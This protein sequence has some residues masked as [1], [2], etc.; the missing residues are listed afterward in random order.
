MTD[1]VTDREQLQALRDWWGRQGQYIVM[2]IAVALIALLGYRLWQRYQT[3]KKLEASAAYQ[4]VMSLF[5]QP[6]ITRNNKDLLQRIS[7]LKQKHSSSPYASLAALMAAQVAVSEKDQ[8]LALTQLQW[9]IQHSDSKQ[10]RQIARLRAAR[11]G[12][13]EENIDLAKTLLATVDDKTFQPLIDEVKGDIAVAEHKPAMAH[14][15]YEQAQSAYEAV[16]QTNP[17]IA[18][19]LADLPAVPLLKPAVTPP[20]QKKNT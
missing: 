9:V 11:V 5:L 13:A 3:Q 8:A 15:A 1:Y 19:K 7:T 14:Q 18:M 2:I 12:L 4:Q 16:G 6:P 10:V 20:A 17:V